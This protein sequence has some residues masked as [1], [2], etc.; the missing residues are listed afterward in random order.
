MVARR[1]KKEKIKARVSRKKTALKIR[2]TSSAKKAAHVNHVSDLLHYNTS[3][4]VKDL[5][6]TLIATLVV[7]GVLVALYYQL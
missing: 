6:R 7:F 3:L 4:I 2:T 1:T 5:T